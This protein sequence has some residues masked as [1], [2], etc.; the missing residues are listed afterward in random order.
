MDVFG[1]T[2]NGIQLERV[3]TLK[4]KLFWFIF[5]EF[6]PETDVNRV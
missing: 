1:T 5:V 6:F 4:S 2:H 3:N